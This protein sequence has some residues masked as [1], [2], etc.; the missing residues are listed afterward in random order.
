MSSILTSD[1]VIININEIQLLCI[2]KNE[3]S[4]VFKETG[5]HVINFAEE[6][7]AQS[8]FKHIK[9]QFESKKL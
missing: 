2:N 4:I 5:K 3:L 7:V 6:T 9:N 1:D 8:F